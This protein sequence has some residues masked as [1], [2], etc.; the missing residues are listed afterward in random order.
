MESSV[1]NPN[2]SV[3]ST[4]VGATGLPAFTAATSL[5]SHP[6][7][8]AVTALSPEGTPTT[9]S[10]V[11]PAPTTS[12]SSTADTGSEGGGAA[13][14]APTLGTGLSS[15]M[16]LGLLAVGTIMLVL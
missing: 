14:A 10:S 7:T 15:F 2:G 16:V 3:N 6:F 1:L 13:D 11:S 9:T 4:P 5:S 12:A 8:S